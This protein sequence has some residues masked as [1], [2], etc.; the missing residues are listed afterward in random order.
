MCYE[1]LLD[2]SYKI[3]QWVEKIF[4]TSFGKF[5]LHRFSV[6]RYRYSHNWIVQKLRRHF[7]SKPVTAFEMKY[8]KDWNCHE[9]TLSISKTIHF[10]L[11]SLSYHSASHKEGKKAQRYLILSSF[12]ENALSIKDYCKQFLVSKME[13]RIRLLSRYLITNAFCS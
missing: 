13:H 1:V 5:I 8:L 11:F 12:T 10:E 7:Y 2:K 3:T 6:Y 9:M 4:K